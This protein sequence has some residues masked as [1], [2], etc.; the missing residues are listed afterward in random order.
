[1]ADI[2]SPPIPSRI[3]G[4]IGGVIVVCLGLGLLAHILVAFVGG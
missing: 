2:D 3:V 1:M 4:E